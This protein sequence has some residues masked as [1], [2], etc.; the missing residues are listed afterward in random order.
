MAGFDGGFGGV[1][2]RRLHQLHDAASDFG[3][4]VVLQEV[5]CLGE[6]GVWEAIG[7]WDVVDQAVLG[8]AGAEV[9][10]SLLAQTVRKGFWNCVR[11]AHASWLTPPSSLTREGKTRGPAM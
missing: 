9:A 5:A 2:L 10:G 6:A 8:L 1:A 4:L 3:A 11:P 7:A